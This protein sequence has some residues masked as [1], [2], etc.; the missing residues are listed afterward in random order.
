MPNSAPSLTG[1][2]PSITLAENS[3]NATPRLLDGDVA[4]TDAEG[5]FGGGK[6]TL[7][8]LLAEDRVAVRNEGVGA[9]QIGVSG[10]DVTYGGVII[11]TV[12][13]GVGDTLTVTLNAAATSAAV[14]A[15]IQNLTYANVSDRPT[16]SRMLVLNVID[17]DGADL[18]L[19]PVGFTELTGAANPFSGISP[20][21]TSSPGFVDLDGDGDLD[22]VLGQDNGTLRSFRNDAGLF[23]TELTGAAN[24]FNGADVGNRAAPG[25]V[26]LDGDGDLDVVIGASNGTI[27]SYRNDAGVFTLLSGKGNPFPIDI[28]DYASPRFVDLDGDGDMDAVIGRDD[29][30]LRSFRNNGGTFTEL[31]GT[32]DPFSGVDVGY[33]SNPSFVDLDND[34]DKDAVIGEFGGTLRA[35]RND[36]GRFT[37]ELTGAANPLAGVDAGYKSSPSFVDLD[38]DGD[39]DAV[40]GRSDG[41]LQVFQSTASRGDPIV[42]NVTA[43]NDA[44][45]LTGFA[46]SLTFAENMVNASPQLLDGDVAFA[47]GEG[48]FAGGKLT[49]SGLLAE[50]RAA[51]RNEGVGAGQI[52]VSGTEVTYGGVIIGTVA[53]GVG[54][55]L[56]VTLNAAATSSA[57]DALIQNLTYANVSNTPT[58]SR[59]LTLNVTDAAGADLGGGAPSFTPLTGAANPFNGLGVS[60]RA[61]PVFVDLDG[62]GDLDALVGDHLGMLQGFHRNSL[63]AFTANGNGHP[64]GNVDVGSSAVPTFGDLDGDGDLDLVVGE[65]EGTLLSFRRESNGSYTPLTGAANP[66]VGID[67]GRF[68][69][70]GFVDLDGDGDKDLIVGEL[71]GAVFSFRNNGNGTFTAMTGADNP[72]NGIVMGLLPAPSFVDLDGDGDMDAVFGIYQGTLRTFRNDAGQFAELIGA[73]NPFSAIDVGFRAAPSFVDLDGDG[74]MDLVVGDE[75]GLLHTF[76]NVTPRGA[77]II[78]NVTPESDNTAPMRAANSGL[79]LAEGGSASITPAMLDYDDAEEA[80]G[81][82]TYTLATAVNNGVLSRNGVALGSGDSFTQADVNAG[83]VAYTHDGGETGGGSFGFSVS[84]GA[85]GTVSNQQFNIFTTPVNDAPALD[86]SGTVA[87]GTNVTAAYTENGAGTIVGGFATVT[88]VDSADFDTGTLTVGFTANGTAADRLTILNQGTTAGKIAVA[89]NVVSYGGVEIGTFAGGTSGSTPLVVTFNANAS[90]EAVQALTRAVAFSNVSDAPSTAARGLDFT[91]TDGDGGASI[92]SAT[93]NVTATNDSPVAVNDSYVVQQG[94]MLKTDA[95]TGVLA[96][97]TDADGNPLTAQVLT[98]PTNYSSLIFNSDGT[99]T[100]YHDGVSTGPDTF[101]YRANDGTANGNVATITINVVTPNQA[102]AMDLNGSDPGTGAA[103]AYAENAAAAPIAP[104]A[105]VTDANSL[106]FGTGTL[107][108]SFTAGGTADDRLTILHQGTTAG[109]IGVSGNMVS[110]GGVQIGTFTGGTS[111]ATPLVV[112]LDADATPAAVQALTRAVAFTNV[113]DAPSTAER[114]VQFVVTDGDGGTSNPVSATVNVSS[115][116]DA[117]VLG[118]PASATLDFVEN[119]PSA[120]ALFAGI[121]LT[122]VDSPPNFGGGTLTLSVS[123]NGGALTFLGAR[124]HTT[125]GGAGIVHVNDSS[126]GQNIGLISGYGTSGVT[127]FNLNANATPAVVEAL[128]QA[129]GLNV[130]GDD[131]DAGDRVAS[132]AINDGGN[133]GG[134]ALASNIVTQTVTVTAV[135]DAPVGTDSEAATRDN[136]YLVFG[137]PSFSNGFSDPEGDSFAGVKIV[138][139]PT[140]GTLDFNGVEVVAGQVFTVAQLD[141]FAL[142]Y[143][144]GPNSAGTSPS[145][146]FAVMDDGGTANGGVNFDQ[147]PNTFTINVTTSNSAP[148]QG[149]NAGLTLDEGAGATITPAMLDYN[150]VEQADGAITYTVTTAATHG[151]LRLNGVALGVGGTFTQADVNNGL[152]TYL[153]DGSETTS[154]SFGFSV[155]DG[156]GGSVTGQSF[157]FTVTPVND[158]PA[159]A[160][161]QGDIATYTEDANTSVFID[162]GLD[163]LVSDFDSANFNGGSLTVSITGG[164]VA[165]RDRLGLFQAGVVT[166]NG[167]NEVRVNGVLIGTVTGNGETGTPTMTI[168]FTTDDAT[169]AR[170]QTLLTTVF[171]GNGYQDP[172]VGARDIMVTLFDG[173]G[174][175]SAY[176]TTVNVVAVNDAPTQGAND[177]L[178]LNEGAGATITA[179]MLDY[180]DAEQADGAITYTVTST[181]N[182]TPRLDGVALG[183]GGTFTQ[184]DINNGLVTYLHDGA[185][186]ASAGFGFSVSDGAGGSV[187][188]QSFAVDVAAVN[189]A[190]TVAFTLAGAKPPVGD[191]KGPAGPLPPQATEQV[192]FSLK[193][194]IAIGDVDAG[195]GTISVTLSVDYGVLDVDAGTSGALVTGTGTGT[196]TITGTL[197]QVRAL[198]GNDPTSAIAFT[199]NTD[200]PPA[201][202]QLTVTVNDNGNTGTDP[203]I[204][205]GAASEEGSASIAI[206]IAPVNDAP[207][208]DLDGT[209][210]GVDQSASYTEDAPGI[211]IGS[212]VTVTDPDSGLGDMMESATITLTGAV[213]G[214]SLALTGA[215]PSGFVAVTTPTAGAITIQITGTGTG[216]QYQALIESIR[217]STTSQDPTVGGTD[218]SRTITVAVND[219][220]NDSAV[221]TAT[222]NIT[223]LDDAPVAQPDAYTITESGTITGGDLFAD[224]GSGADSDPDGPPLVVAAV[225]GSDANVNGQIALASGALLTVNDDG[226]FDYD[227]NHAFD[228]TGA[229]AS[230]TDSFTYTLADGDTATVSITI[231][232]IDSDDTLGGTPGADVLAGGQGD[233]IYHVDN[234]GDQVIELDGEGTSDRVIAGISYTLGT[235]SFVETLEAA[236]GTAPLT[237][238]GNGFD[239]DVIGNAGANVLHGG[240][241]TDVLTGLAGNDI[242]YTDVATTQIVE[243]GSGGSDTLYTSVSYTLGGNAEVETLSTNSYGST[244]AINL[245]GNGFDQTII[246][247]AGANILHGGGGVDVLIGLGGNDV[248]YVDV[249]ATTVQEAGGGGND[250][251]YAS[252]SYVLAANQSVE[253][254]STNSLAATTAINLTG[255]AFDQTIFGNAGNNILHGGGG[256]DFLHGLGGNDIYYV[257]VAAVQVFENEGDGTD[258]LYSSVSYTLSGNAEVELLS[259]NSHGSTAAIDLTGNGFGQTLVGNAGANIL[260][261]G[262]GADVLFGLGGDDIYYVDV[263]ATRVIETA[264]GGNDALYTSVSYALAA[265]SEVELLSANDHAAAT[266]IDL[267]GNG[268]ANTVVGNAG[269]NVLNG[270]GGADALYGMGGADTFAFTT[271]LGSGNVDTIIDFFGIGSDGDDMIALDDEA[272]AGLALGSLDPNAFVVGTA[273]LDADD[274]IIYNGLTGALSFDA[275]GNGAGAAVQFATLQAAPSLTAVDFVVI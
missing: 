163:A 88:D 145:F 216:A 59:A 93:V 70:P 73:S 185:E 223:A 13:G 42:V 3:V 201:S 60:A 109:K 255:N 177:G 229:G 117:P 174:G 209:A 244:A 14:D 39:L 143:T 232:G 234:V 180:D 75:Y 67:I 133:G 63:G 137:P 120:T 161:L 11:G 9:G 197:A 128:A 141:S 78:V 160:N 183:V 165:A 50:D 92:A 2:A 51:V 167:S 210:G 225:N 103:F 192:A 168:T 26:D 57:V 248:Y 156:A 173:D 184:A 121:S 107:T 204:S 94:G 257:D 226:T 36:A 198:F 62:D 155:S 235:G 146:T 208:V 56:T 139:L 54:G 34:G 149:A 44:P 274:R 170:V 266:A 86:L 43:V 271:A 200:A 175:T 245:T 53:G 152:V 259:T 68:S 77:P 95:A 136:E 240:G 181:A 40:V 230:A 72:F 250:V 253:I 188:G 207:A 193:G 157:A 64:L 164:F 203:G 142:R 79:T 20:G 213:A 178:T 261:G 211:A 41:T 265:G 32:A 135:N 227:P 84:D 176:T 21:F 126:T 105:A 76:D 46:P 247:N 48:N 25:F 218:G 275:D 108:V 55:T 130:A 191:A 206:F 91:L 154:A 100:Y 4:F 122:D 262:G 195:A 110:Y 97:D 22:L 270:G 90:I 166:V 80:D 111:G 187:T 268:T 15:L 220:A 18:G 87:A 101:T 5:N 1:F 150:D 263:A 273:A 179:A 30:T 124:F 172:V 99:F 190:P 219:G 215:L 202:A 24:P 106:D 205:G 214:D 113:S 151:T 233:D 49:L 114:T 237:L 256:V 239:N 16:A 47:D 19:G 83:L 71:N 45:T 7:S 238:I 132:L 85:G 221:A 138:T 196:V 81:A 272:F 12:A 98:L 159:I 251:V 254:L 131:P 104:F 61:A 249:A 228:S 148:T 74:D 267:T 65:S 123:G 236:A 66:L 169:A 10:T 89:G 96:N 246:G 153:H 119:A 144:P 27:H 186:T 199:A 112:M 182:G 222:V 29:G 194:G 35:F 147:S 115:V 82:I 102:P 69:R 6:L 212:G 116:N 23:T 260:N 162:A 118:A 224:N 252:V 269:A 158:A 37:V 242:Y 8:G 125:P 28:G 231:T 52:G 264:G 258:A 38:G 129:F 134:G 58:A 171:Y 33:S 17:A 31:T 189:D 217:Y 140:T 243:T 127:V 241:G